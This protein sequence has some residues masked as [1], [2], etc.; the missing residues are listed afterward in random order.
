[1]K[2]LAVYVAPLLV[3]LLR[4]SEA[5]I[6]L[7]KG[8]SFATHSALSSSPAVETFFAT[9]KQ[10]RKLPSDE[11]LQAVL[12]KPQN[13]LKI[14]QL[15]Q[16]IVTASTAWTYDPNESIYGPL[17]CTVAAFTPNDP[18]HAPPLWERISLKDDNIKGQQY[19]ARA[20]QDPPDIAGTLINYSEIW[21]KALHL[22]A[23]GTSVPVQNKTSSS[24]PSSFWW[25]ALLPS[26]NN[27]SQKRTCPDDYVAT[28]NGA[29]LHLGNFVWKLPIEGSSIL[30]V[31]YADPQLRIFISP[32]T[33]D[34]VVGAWEESGLV[35]VQVRSDL[36]TPNGQI[37]DLRQ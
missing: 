15:V 11:L 6:V 34:S 33:S 3:Q 25:D 8:R 12:T 7:P 19:T 24:K 10:M 1:M 5:F 22:R 23:T 18:N 14:E 9:T 4:R 27:P 36:V 17:Y 37:I 28:V 20:R 21:G 26:I 30:R 31:L 29:S 16:S 2:K 32:A 35:V 13:L